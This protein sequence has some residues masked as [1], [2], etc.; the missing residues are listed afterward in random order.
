MS[1]FRWISILARPSPFN[2]HLRKTRSLI[3]NTSVSGCVHKMLTVSYFLGCRDVGQSLQ[4]PIRMPVQW[5]ATLGKLPPHD[6]GKQICPQRENLSC[7]LAKY[8]VCVSAHVT[9]AHGI[10]RMTAILAMV[11]QWFRLS[12]VVNFP[13]LVHLPS[14]FMCCNV[15]YEQIVLHVSSVEK[16]GHWF[17]SL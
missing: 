2:P 9:L 16:L 8:G 14:L 11:L 10:L 5:D 6:Q 13:S 12:H 4:T 1:S 7:L 3:A 15:P 17:A